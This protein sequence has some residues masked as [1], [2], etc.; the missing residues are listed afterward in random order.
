MSFKVL[1][2]KIQRSNFVLFA[3]FADN[4]IFVNMAL[5]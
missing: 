1:P 5:Q 4:V 3:Y 2:V